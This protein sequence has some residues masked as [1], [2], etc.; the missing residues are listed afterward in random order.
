MMIMMTIF[1][2]IKDNAI[3]HFQRYFNEIL[4]NENF[5]RK[6]LNEIK[7]NF[8]R[9]ITITLKNAKGVII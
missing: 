1:V 2:I 5:H 6:I 3:A 4:E 7:S 9:K 8:K